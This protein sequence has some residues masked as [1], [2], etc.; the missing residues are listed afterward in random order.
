VKR[1]YYDGNAEIRTRPD[2]AVLPVED[3]RDKMAPHLKLRIANP[4]GKGHSVSW[5]Q[6]APAKATATSCGLRI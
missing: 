1:E 5:H 3:E 6:S 4:E 2:M